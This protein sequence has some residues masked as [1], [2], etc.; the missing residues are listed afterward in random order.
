MQTYSRSETDMNV[1]AKDD[2]Q[3][4]K[5]LREAVENTSR[6][7]KEFPGFSAELTVNDQG[8]SYSGSVTV[9][10]P[11]E[12][13]VSLPDE[14]LQKW[15]QSQIA[16]MAVH[17]SHRSFEDGDGRYVLTLGEE[18]EHPYGRLVY[19]HGDGMNS[20]YRVKDGR[21]S[22]INRS[23]ERMKF[24]INVE[25][26]LGTE[27][28]K[29]LTTRYTVYYFSPQDGRLLQAESYVDEPAVIARPGAT[30]KLYLP[31]KRRITFTDQGETVARTLTFQT[32]RFLG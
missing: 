8:K 22:Q 19:I 28:G 26:S 9:K 21:I 20:R 2:P 32:H 24:T 1:Q 17:R 23:G 4:R 10:S 3:A 13:E 29:F 12:V 25:E 27:D 31:G 16:M 11:R 5:L 15:A 6:W 18:D 7:G 14:G 30:G